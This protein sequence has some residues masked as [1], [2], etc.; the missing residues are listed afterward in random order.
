MPDV[1][2]SL[3]LHHA[4]KTVWGRWLYLE[5]I[6][7]G[8][9]LPP[10]VVTAEGIPMQAMQ[11]AVTG[12]AAVGHDLEA[13]VERQPIP[14]QDLLVSAQSSSSSYPICFQPSIV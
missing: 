4:A 3:R 12:E 14:Q 13:Q 1:P 10:R 5:K 2:S 9:I 11:P 8:M 7:A 6:A